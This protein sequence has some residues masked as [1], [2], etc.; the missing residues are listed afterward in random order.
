MEQSEADS[1]NKYTVCSKC[2]MKFINDDE[3]ILKLILIMKD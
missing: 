2:K 1:S 3:H